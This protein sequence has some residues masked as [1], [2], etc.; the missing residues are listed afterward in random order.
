MSD[1]DLN[2]EANRLLLASDDAVRDSEQ[3]L[4]FAQAQFGEAAA[5]PFEVAI[6]A[7]GSLDQVL[8][9]RSSGYRELDAAARATGVLL[10]NELGLD[11]GIDQRPARL[12]GREPA[13]RLD[14]HRAD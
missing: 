1:D 13:L 3:E 12:L 6:A 11:P 5:A 7:D 4:G 8:V 9:R 14:Q 10:L 2:A